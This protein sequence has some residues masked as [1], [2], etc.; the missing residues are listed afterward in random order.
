MPFLLGLL[1][2]VKDFTNDTKRGKFYRR[3]RECAYI[4]QGSQTFV[5]QTTVSEWARLFNLH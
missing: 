4:E 1:V 3:H 2:L 5:E